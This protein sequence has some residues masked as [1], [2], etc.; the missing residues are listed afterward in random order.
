MNQQIGKYFLEGLGERRYLTNDL[1][2]SVSVVTIGKLVAYERT[3]IRPVALFVEQGWAGSLGL[4]PEGQEKIS[5]SNEEQAATGSPLKSEMSFLPVSWCL[6]STASLRTGP[7]AHRARFLPNT[8]QA[9]CL[10]LR[11]TAGGKG[12]CFEFTWRR[13][14]LAAMH[15]P[16]AVP[17]SS[18]HEGAALP[19]RLESSARF[20][21]SEKKWGL[22]LTVLKSVLHGALTLWDGFRWH[23]NRGFCGQ[24]TLG[25]WVRV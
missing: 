1:A 6:T 22:V 10:S 13:C 20:K 12:S 25:N 17:S 18:C 11:S 5:S 19:C 24:E 16:R 9:M 14:L 7:G 3:S 15:L 2:A 21:H 23:M 4:T 8:Q